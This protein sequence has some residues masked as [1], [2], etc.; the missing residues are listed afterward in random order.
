MQTFRSNIIW[1]I[2]RCGKHEKKKGK[3]VLF[4]FL[5]DSIL[6]VRCNHEQQISEIEF[7]DLR[8]VALHCIVTVTDISVTK[9]CHT[10]FKS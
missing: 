5:R 10:V 1:F 3:F 9:S 6:S 8:N 2:H 4:F 7:S